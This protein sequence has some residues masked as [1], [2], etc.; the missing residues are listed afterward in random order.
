MSIIIKYNTK[1]VILSYT[2]LLNTILSSSIFLTCLFYLF[3][4]RTITKRYINVHQLLIILLK[5]LS[6]NLFFEKKKLILIIDAL[7][8][9]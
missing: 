5:D 6:L 4:L 9:V 3:Y 1:I 7:I 2:S 8:Q